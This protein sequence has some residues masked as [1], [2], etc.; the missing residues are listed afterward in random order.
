[1]A[2]KKS[3]KQ[4]KKPDAS[5]QSGIERR[6]RHHPLVFIGTVLVLVIVVIAFVL[7]PAIVPGE[8]LAASRLEFGSWNGKPIVYSSGGFFALMVE[9][10]SRDYGMGNYQAWRS[11]FEAAAERTAVLDIMETSGYTPSKSFVDRKVAELPFFKENGRFSAVKYNRMD[12][13]ARIKLWQ[14]MRND[15]TVNIYHDDAATIKTAGAEAEFIGRMALTQR[16]FS[17]TAFP[18][19]SYPDSESASYANKN[20]DMFKTVYL[21]R[22]TVSGGK[23]EAQAVMDKIRSGEITFEDAARTQSDD[24]YADRGGDTGTRMAFELSAEIPDEDQ[25]RAV[26]NLPK[27][28]ISDLLELSSGWVFFRANEESRTSNLQDSDTLSKIRGFL[29]DSERGVIEDWLITQAENFAQEARRIGFTGAAGDA[30]LRVYEFGPLPINYGD[31]P[32]FKSLN[33]FQAP[34]LR[35]AVSDENF[36]RTAFSTPVGEPSRPVVLGGGENNIV[37]LYPGEELTDEGDAAENTRTIFSSWWAQNETL[38]SVA[39]SVL[40]SDKFNDNFI[41]TYFRLFSN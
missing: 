27:D 7:V 34:G 19:S 24:E 33:S 17:M 23:R 37:I 15:V 22:I 38:R 20:A 8:G 26:I 1:M 36:W 35:D 41:S 2:E 16:K 5:G 9:R 25:W 30:D 40:S 32:L 39:S 12:A 3:E 13:S 21:S 14:D 29:M 10:N 4:G 18:Y 28:T 6:F 31:S 11:A